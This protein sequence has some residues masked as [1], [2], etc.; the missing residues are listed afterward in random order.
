L[1]RD[2]LEIWFRQGNKKY[3][4]NLEDKVLGIGHME[5]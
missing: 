1:R 2:E 3:I 5:D 4:R